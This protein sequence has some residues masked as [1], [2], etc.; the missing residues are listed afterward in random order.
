ML[1]LPGTHWSKTTE[2]VGPGV[3]SVMLASRSFAVIGGFC[4]KEEKPF[5]LHS[6]DGLSLL[7]SEHSFK[8]FD[9][10]KQNCEQF[11]FGKIVLKHENGNSK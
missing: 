5:L 11:W 8:C 7:L 2:P 3:L 1:S 4:E 6:G 9:N 10:S